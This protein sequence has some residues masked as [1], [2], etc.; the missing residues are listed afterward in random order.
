MA[1]PHPWHLLEAEIGSS[2]NYGQGS[3]RL[4]DFFKGLEESFSAQDLLH[5]LWA[6]DPEPKWMERFLFSLLDISPSNR[7]VGDRALAGRRM[8]RLLM[9]AGVSQL[10]TEAERML[11]ERLQLMFQPAGVAGLEHALVR[12]RGLFKRALFGENLNEE[13]RTFLTLLIRTEAE[14]LKERV[15]WLSENV[16]P[17][18]MKTMAR[19]LPRLR[20][21]DEAVHEGLDLAKKFESGEP[22]GQPTMTF[23]YEMKGPV[24]QK[25]IKEIRKSPRLVK[26]VE[27]LDLQQQKRISTL[28][29]IALGTMQRWIFQLRGIALGPIDW[30]VRALNATDGETFS[31]DAGE[32]AATLLPRVQNSGIQMHGQK[33]VG[34]FIEGSFPE[35][36]GRDLA[37]RPLDRAEEKVF[38]DVKTLIAQNITRDGVIEALLS[39]AKIYGTPGLIAYIVQMC[40]SAV[41]LSK[42]AKSRTLHSGFANR[43]VP[44]ELLKSPC[45]IPV[46]LIRPFVSTKYVGM[47]DLR[48]LVKMRGGLRREVRMMVEEFLVGR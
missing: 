31:L 18:N 36:I 45:N 41:I 25:W 47:V 46:N 5:S 28:D 13:G 34:R 32:A 6:A 33:L 19:V 24:Y 9:R 22:I 43:D 39:N 37:T 11:A 42:I 26:L 12:G 20:I 16:D 27:L 2:Q 17:Y 23:E 48:H 30:L 44:L 3:R 35:L 4:A 15:D 10:F 29:L 14:C 7:Q 38:L 21:Y 1:L 8:R 40:R